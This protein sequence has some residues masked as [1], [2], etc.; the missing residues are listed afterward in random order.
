[1]IKTRKRKKI[2][3][4]PEET[5][6]NELL[7][8]AK[9]GSDFKRVSLAENKNTPGEVLIIL[10]NDTLATVYNAAASNP[11]INRDVF[12]RI[13]QGNL[14]GSATFYK[15]F[16]ENES[17]KEE[18]IYEYIDFLG[19]LGNVSGVIIPML[20][21]ER[22][23]DDS[24]EWLNIYNK[25]KSILTINY[26][27][28]LPIYVFWNNFFKYPKRNYDEEIILA[29]LN[30]FGDLISSSNNGNFNFIVGTPMETPIVLLKIFELT[31]NPDYAPQIARD[32]FL[33]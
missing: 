13:L 24:N 12:D 20:E 6:I 22:F 5:D 21:D 27:R 17:F 33:F 26:M 15:K 25:I 9:K 4:N 29:I 19:S 11:N 23:S 2:S 31:N 7:R 30:D 18:W 10:V 14:N 28:E 32:M 3:L 1:M 8:I 16:F